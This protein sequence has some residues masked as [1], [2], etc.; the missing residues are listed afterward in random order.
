MYSFIYLAVKL[1]ETQKRTEFWRGKRQRFDLLK[2]YIFIY[3]LFCQPIL[4]SKWQIPKFNICLV[5]IG[6]KF[7]F[8][9][10]YD[11][12]LIIDKKFRNLRLTTSIHMQ[13]KKFEYTL[14][15]FFFNCLD[16]ENSQKPQLSQTGDLPK[17]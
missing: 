9:L 5:K 15:Q 2:D 3:I 6:Q 11:K 8:S 17:A 10:W 4:C 14:S 1:K 7:S 13:L 16:L 12:N